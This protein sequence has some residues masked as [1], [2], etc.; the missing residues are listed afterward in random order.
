MIGM[1]SL[2]FVTVTLPPRVDPHTGRIHYDFRTSHASSLRAPKA[3]SEDTISIRFYALA[4][5]STA[6]LPAGIDVGPDRSRIWF[7]ARWIDNL[8]LTFEDFLVLLDPLTTP[9]VEASAVVRRFA[10]APETCTAIHS[11]SLV[12]PFVTVAGPGV[13]YLPADTFRGM[14]W[15]SVSGGPCNLVADD[16]VWFTE[17]EWSKVACFQPDSGTITEWPVPTPGWL[18]AIHAAQDTTWYTNPGGDGYLG[19]L[20]PAANQF[21]EWIVP[22][23]G[24]W[25]VGWP[26]LDRDQEGNIW[27]TRRRDQHFLARVKLEPGNQAGFDM[28]TLPYGLV[29]GPC[30]LL[31][32]R[33]GKVWYS[34]M[35]LDSGGEVGKIGR[36]DP[37]SGALT[38]WT[39]PLIGA[40]PYYL[41]LDDVG[42]CWFVECDSNRVGMVNPSTNIVSEYAPLLTALTMSYDLALDGAGNIWLTHGGNCIVKFTGVA[43]IEEDATVP[44]APART[45]LTGSNIVR[46]TLLLQG[47]QPAILMDIT[48][49]KKATL[50]PGA[51]D[52]RHLPSGVYFVCDESGSA[53]AKVLVRR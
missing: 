34:V 17:S 16:P 48:G 43:A 35:S 28:W 52:I 18:V 13:T 29:D 51:N 23:T 3:L 53:N 1:L 22:G 38:E 40:Q 4:T 25:G 39:L 49:N 46:G 31:V 42:N 6:V 5:E 20:V 33:G 32:D 12:D 9:G 44:I 7:L 11:Q 50:K 37:G 8:R 15:W 47:E 10:V 36:L 26:G 24:F 14:K 30:D 27:V 19:R 41:E 21:S 45:R 2:F